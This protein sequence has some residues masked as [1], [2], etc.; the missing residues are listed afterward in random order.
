MRKLIWFGVGLAA[1]AA[2]YRAVWHPGARPASFACCQRL[3]VS[4]H[5]SGQAVVL[6]RHSNGPTDCAATGSAPEASHPDVARDEGQTPVPSGGVIELSGSSTVVPPT[7]TIPDGEEPPLALPEAGTEECEERAAV[8]PVRLMPYCDDDE[9]TPARMPYADGEPAQ[10]KSAP[11]RAGWFDECEPFDPDAMP[12]CREDDNLSRQYPGC[13]FSG[14]PAPAGKPA[15][16]KRTQVPHEKDPVL[17]VLPEVEGH[18]VPPAGSDADGRGPQASR[19]VS[20]AGCL[21][22]T[23]LKVWTAAEADSHARQPV[24]TLELRPGDLR[25]EGTVPQ[26]F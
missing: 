23:A 1:L 17:P 19:G 6:A 5:V 21:R 14:A 18:A 10:Q 13:P 20:P 3:Q 16:K 26:P 11:A 7:I 22:H 25:P 4:D 24:D 12:A 9:E 8:L 2:G 15:P